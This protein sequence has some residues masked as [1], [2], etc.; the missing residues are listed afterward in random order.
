[1]LAGLFRTRKPAPDNPGAA[2]AKLGHKQRREK[3]RAKADQ[4]RADMGLPAV[5]WPA[6]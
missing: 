2:L 4:M 3:V 1:M 5:K 6:L